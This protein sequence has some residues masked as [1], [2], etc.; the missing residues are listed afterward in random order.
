M[1]VLPEKVQA[2]EGEHGSHQV[3]KRTTAAVGV[4]FHFECPPT[5]GASSNSNKNLENRSTGAVPKQLPVKKDY[6]LK[7]APDVLL[8]SHTEED[9]IAAVVTLQSLLMQFSN[10]N[11]R[12]DFVNGK[13]GSNINPNLLPHIDNLRYTLFPRWSGGDFKSA[14][15]RSTY[16]VQHICNL[17]NKSHELAI[18]SEQDSVDSLTYAEWYNALDGIAASR[19]WAITPHEKRCVHI[20]KTNHSDPVVQAS[21]ESVCDSEFSVTPADIVDAPRAS[22]SKGK[23]R[24]KK[25]EEVVISDSSSA[26][27]DSQSESSAVSDSSSGSSASVLATHRRKRFFDKRE[28]VKPKV[29]E[30]DGKLDLSDFFYTFEVYFSSNFKGNSRDKTQVLEQFLKGDLLKVYN[31]R[32]G[33]KQRYSDMKMELLRYYRDKKIGSR[34]YWKAV[35]E[36]SSPEPDETYDLY[37]MRLM[38]IAELAYPK[39]KLECARQ[40]RKQFLSSVSSV[41]ANKVADAERMLEITSKRKRK[42]LSFEELARMAT[43]LQE[44]ESGKTR[45]IM[46]AELPAEGSGQSTRAEKSVQTGPI[47]PSHG[48]ASVSRVWSRNRTFNSRQSLQ[49]RQNSQQCSFCHRTNHHRDNCWRAANLCGICGENHPIDRCPNYDPEYR[50]QPNPSTPNL[51]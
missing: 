25:I 40:L 18:V 8:E 17:L 27:A 10:V 48:G 45:T 49:S 7:V 33:C 42:Y 32:G 12:A 51:N 44:E 26:D 14:R 43:K 6:E 36:R 29:F 11:V 37:G 30:M 3:V 41:I 13:F 35:F 23:F 16:A 24:R 39:D 46:W 4:D 9:A 15:A 1:M 2:G 22:K 38:S 50:G 5:D 47:H 28:R 21:S 34:S 31:A 20:L 19:Y